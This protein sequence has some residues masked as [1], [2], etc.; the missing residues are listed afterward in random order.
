M[1][2]LIEIVK[3]ILAIACCFLTHKIMILITA[4]YCGKKCKYDCSKCK[5]WSCT[6]ETIYDGKYKNFLYDNYKNICG[7]EDI[8]ERIIDSNNRPN[9]NENK[10][11]K[12]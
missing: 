10:D 12:I 4:I 7:K 3:I 2:L 6:N 5:M 11:I 9:Q 1:N 8:N